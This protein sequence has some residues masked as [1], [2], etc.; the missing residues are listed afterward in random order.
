MSESR[1]K[2]MKPLN[3]ISAI[4]LLRL[5]LWFGSWGRGGFVASH[6]PV[7]AQYTHCLGAVQAHKRSRVTLH[8]QAPQASGSVPQS[9]D[10]QGVACGGIC[11]GLLIHCSSTPTQ[12]GAF[13]RST[14]F[15]GRAVFCA[16]GQSLED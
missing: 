10:V 15:S 6:T 5:F 8:S 9:W 13:T 11:S 4:L 2:R 7:F 1:G 14:G 12:S 16:R 3:S